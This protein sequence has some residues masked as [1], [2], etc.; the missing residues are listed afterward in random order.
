MVCLRVMFSENMSISFDIFSLL[1]RSD[2]YL[3][4]LC[5]TAIITRKIYYRSVFTLS[6]IAIVKISTE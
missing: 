6:Q 2:K 1:A 5:Y 4:S 3:P